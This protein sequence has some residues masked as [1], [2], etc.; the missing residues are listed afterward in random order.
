MKGTAAFW[1]RFWRGQAGWA[2]APLS[3]LLLPLEL[4]FS[5]GVSL[6]AWRAA[7]VWLSALEESSVYGCMTWQPPQNS[8]SVV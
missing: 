6:R 7:R 2:L 5:L 8:R 3:L 1:R 4:L